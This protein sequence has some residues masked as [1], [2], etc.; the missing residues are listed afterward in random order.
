MKQDQQPGGECF[1][2]WAVRLATYLQLLDIDEW[3]DLPPHFQ[4]FF[5]QLKYN[6]IIGPLVRADYKSFKLGE[7]KFNTAS[8]IAVRYGITEYRLL[9]IVNK[10]LSQPATVSAQT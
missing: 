6:D 5:S 10:R 2:K 7:S 3:D 1:K 9:R 4:C 8:Q